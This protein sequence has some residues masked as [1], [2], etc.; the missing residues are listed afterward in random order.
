M[1]TDKWRKGGFGLYC[2]GLVVDEDDDWI[3]VSPLLSRFV[4]ILLNPTCWPIAIFPR[5]FEDDTNINVLL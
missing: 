1:Y 4:T 2:V 3:L 5:T